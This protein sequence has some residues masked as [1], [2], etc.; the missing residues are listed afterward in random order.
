MPRLHKR[1][2]L[3]E[4]KKKI[5]EDNMNF[6]WFYYKKCIVPKCKKLCFIEQD[7][8]ID[9]LYWGICKAAD[10]YNPD[11]G[12]F[13][14]ICKWYFRGEISDYL[15]KRKLYYSRFELTPFGY[16]DVQNNNYD[17]PLQFLVDDRSDVCEKLSFEDI[18]CIFKEAELTCQEKKVLIDYYKHDLTYKEISIAIG[19][20]RE[21][22]RQI[23]IGAI[24]KVREYINKKGLNCKDL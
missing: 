17:N 13:T 9:C 18:N 24:E 1:H 5:V 8:I 14:T 22:V 23:A 2:Y 19:C 16:N 6:L 15:R 4:N 20:S 3:T 10:A 7:D 21:K 12:A 11:K